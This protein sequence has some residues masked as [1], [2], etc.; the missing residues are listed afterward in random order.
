[1]DIQQGRGREGIVGREGRH[2]M[3]G[4][5]FTAGKP[6]TRK[7]HD[8]REG[9]SEAHQSRGC[10]CLS[11]AARKASEYG[12]VN[13]GQPRRNGQCTQAAKRLIKVWHEQSPY[14]LACYTQA[15]A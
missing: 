10:C 4:G 13:L 7:S 9:N 15:R 6:A 3:R 2:R 8:Q 14:V 1:M 11:P 12:I 5:R